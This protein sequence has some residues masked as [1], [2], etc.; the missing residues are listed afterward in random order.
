MR[1]QSDEAV[2]CFS[3]SLTRLRVYGKGKTIVHQDEPADRLIFLCR[4]LLKMTR[5]EEEGEEVIV[6]LVSPCSIIGGLNSLLSTNIIYWTATTLTD[7]SET[8]YMDAESFTRICEAHP[9]IVFGFLRYMSE[10]LRLAYRSTRNMRLPVEAKLR[11]V[12]AHLMFL[13]HGVCENRLIELPFSHR[14]LAQLA[15]MTS[16]TLSRALCALQKGGIIKVEKG[17]IR[18]LQ[19]EALKKWSEAPN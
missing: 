6:S 1:D 11:G 17:G 3:K 8:A 14:V 16:E 13:F 18:I 5:I 12:L 10:R 9:K 4:G 15:Q 2:D 7:V 19:A